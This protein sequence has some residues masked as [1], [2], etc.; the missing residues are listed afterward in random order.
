MPNT[1]SLVHEKVL[2][3]KLKQ[4]QK[5]GWRVVNLH[6][7]SPDGIAVKDGKIVAVEILKRLKTERRGFEQIKKHGKYVYR[8]SGGATLTSKRANYD[9][10]DDV[11]FD[12]FW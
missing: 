5:D 7:K 3:L 10:F 2:E 4:M 8:F 6:A 9:M 12:F 1:G 11:I